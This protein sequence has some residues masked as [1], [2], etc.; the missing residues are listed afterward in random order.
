MKSV[1]NAPGRTDFLRWDR[2]CRFGLPHLGTLSLNSLVVLLLLLF[3]QQGDRS[4]VVVP[5][6]LA[7][8]Q[9]QNASGSSWRT[10]A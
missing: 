3:N 8:H 9:R 2:N 4:L 6:V 7:S 1:S 5:V 10:A